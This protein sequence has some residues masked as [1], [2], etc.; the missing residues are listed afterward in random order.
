VTELTTMLQGKD[1]SFVPHGEL[2]TAL[3]SS[4]PGWDWGQTTVQ[5][6]G[7]MAVDVL[8][9]AVWLAEMGSPARDEIVQ[10]RT[11]LSKSLAEI[12]A[13]RHDRDRYW[14][15]APRGGQPGLPPMPARS[16]QGTAADINQLDAWLTDALAAW[17]NIWDSDAARQ[18]LYNQ[19]LTIAEVLD[20][21]ADTIGDVA[22]A[23]P[24]PQQTAL[25]P[26]HSEQ[27]Q[28]AALYKYLFVARPLTETMTATKV[29]KRML[30]L[31]VV[32]LSFT[33]AS[34]QVE[35]GVEL[36]KVSSNR[37]R[38]TSLR[39]VLP[40]VVEDQRLASGPDGRC[41][42]NRA[43]APF[44]GTAPPD[45]LYR[46]TS[47]QRPGPQGVAGQTNPRDCCALWSS[48]HRMARAAV[49]TARGSVRR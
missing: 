43:D 42:A 5:R 8:K 25:D 12:R 14:L 21:Y 7:D 49:A 45:L 4:G 44:T 13:D 41:R 15:T 38:L 9:R 18:R 36:I 3:S 19:A 35:Q 46:S 2:D 30:K 47:G 32:Q 34:P 23:A 37:E 26:D 1:L 48:R 16:S 17:R 11:T 33:G 28:L 20:A 6:L 31:D 24:G 39:R 40:I 22:N 10:C 27:E 29:L